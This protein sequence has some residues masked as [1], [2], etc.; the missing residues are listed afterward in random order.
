MQMNPRKLESLLA[1]LRRLL[2]DFILDGSEGVRDLCQKA[3]GQLE[4][5][6]GI[7]YPLGLRSFVEV[8][9]LARRQTAAS[10][11]ISELDHID[12]EFDKE[13]QPVYAWAKAVLTRWAIGTNE[14]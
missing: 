12:Y 11:N 2:K 7:K 9:E 13:I 10:M 4:P 14:Q 3:I 1:I 8:V 5:F 6:D